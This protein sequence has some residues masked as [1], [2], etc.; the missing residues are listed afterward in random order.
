MH[1]SGR[2]F[3][4]ICRRCHSLSAPHLCLSTTR[5]EAPPEPALKSEVSDIQHHRLPRE[6]LSKQSLSLLIHRT[7]IAA[8]AID[9]IFIILLQRKRLVKRGATKS[10]IGPVLLSRI[11]AA[12]NWHTEQVHHHSLFF[13][14]IVR[15][16]FDLIS[17]LLRFLL[18]IIRSWLRHNIPDE[19]RLST[20]GL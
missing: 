20:R 3:H 18:I 12:L 10:H 13:Y 15:V 4:T 11:R 1:Y 5:T 14:F 17:F 16:E 8:A 7:N 2:K 19:E 6:R 9:L